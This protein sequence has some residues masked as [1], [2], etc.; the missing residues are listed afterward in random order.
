MKGNT[1]KQKRLK[2][3]LEEIKE[4]NSLFEA[5]HIKLQLKDLKNENKDLKKRLHNR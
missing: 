5:K 1:A 4:N 2:S 3:Q